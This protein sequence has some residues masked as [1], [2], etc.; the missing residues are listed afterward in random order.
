MDLLHVPIHFRFQMLLLA[1]V[2]FI[3]AVLFEHFF[4]DYIVFQKLKNT[5]L[6]RDQRPSYEQL[7][8]QT[9]DLHWLHLAAS[10]VAI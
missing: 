10:T 4:V 9:T 7:R 6:Y 1:G 2:H 8:I 3:L 5:K